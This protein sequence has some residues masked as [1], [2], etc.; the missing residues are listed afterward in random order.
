MSHGSPI[1]L[2]H[3]ENKL[4]LVSG[5]GAV[6]EHKVRTLLDAQ[7]HVG[8]IA[9]QLTEGSAELAHLGKID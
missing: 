7:A 3:L 5:G 2:T 9:P 6:A 8:V 1:T 4:C